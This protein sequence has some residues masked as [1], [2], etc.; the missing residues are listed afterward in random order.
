MRRGPG[1]RSSLK[2]KS[3]ADRAISIERWPVDREGRLA[4]LYRRFWTQEVV[5]YGLS[6]LKEVLDK[7]TPGPET[8]EGTSCLLSNFPALV[9]SQA[10][11]VTGLLPYT[12]YEDD[13]Y[14]LALGFWSGQDGQA[15]AL[16]AEAQALARHLG[17]RRLRVTLTNADLEGLMLYQRLNFRLG[18]V[19]LGA[20]SGEKGASGLPV[21]DELILYAPV[22]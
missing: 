9:A 12:L 19:R 11:E 10:G 4:P 7:F 16:L 17:R 6:C 14:L 13:L 5:V 21:F 8:A 18:E 1:G 20:Y 15:E 22:D 3:Q 2:A